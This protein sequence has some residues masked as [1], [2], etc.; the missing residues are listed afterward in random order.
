[1]NILKVIC[2]SLV[3]ACLFSVGCS[4]VTISDYKNKEAL[5]AYVSTRLALAVMNTPDSP[6]E[7]DTELCDGS[8]FITHGDGHKTECPGCSACE[9][10]DGQE[11]KQSN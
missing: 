9:K 7:E 4:P 2:S 11:T 1:M 3:L 10:K 5:R 6:D 8:G